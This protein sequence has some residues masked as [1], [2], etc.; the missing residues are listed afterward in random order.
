MKSELQL[1]CV[2]VFVCVCVCVF[3][4]L[5]VCV[6]LSLSLSH[7]RVCLMCVNDH[8]L[9]FEK[10]SPS[11]SLSFNGNEFDRRCLVSLTIDYSAVDF[12]PYRHQTPGLR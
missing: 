8:V 10:R 3:F 2:C 9:G 7:A 4:F 5:C 6:C 12:E 11:S 1:V